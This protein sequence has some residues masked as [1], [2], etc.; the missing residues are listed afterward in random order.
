MTNADPNSA[1]RRLARLTIGLGGTVL[2]AAVAYFLF[3]RFPAARRSLL[4]I[5]LFLVAAL[6]GARLWTDVAR[7][8]VPPYNVAE[9]AVE[10][11]ITRDGVVGRIP[12][13]SAAGADAVVEQI[14][15][16]DATDAVEALVVKLNTPGG[17]IVPSE[18]IRLAAAQFDGPTV[19]YATDTCASGGY[20][21][22]S[23]CDELWAR[24]AS[25]VGSIGVIGSRVNVTELADRLGISYERFAAGQYKDAGV[26]LDELD[27]DDREYLQ[28]LVDGFYDDFVARV[29]EGRGMDPEA[30][31]GTEARVYLGRDAHEVGLVDE[32]GTR[33]DVLD[34][35]AEEVGADAVPE[36]FDPVG[37]LGDRI[38]LSARRVAYALGAG[39]AAVV[40]PGRFRVR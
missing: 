22:A 31:R 7:S 3:V 2:T 11:P 5:V 33:E 14:E 29:V 18:D 27:D 37:G 17:E 9:V 23:G 12:S 6:A 34:R 35:I 26:P 38:S 30:V 19:A 15:R 39:L 28:G 40:D 25:L 8:V 24:E 4:G 1:G 20:W 16:A 36:R 10:G 32:V 13:R 21:I